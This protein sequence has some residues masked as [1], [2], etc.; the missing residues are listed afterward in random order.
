MYPARYLDMVRYFA[1]RLRRLSLATGAA[2]AL[3]GA[4]GASYATPRPVDAAPPSPPA[5]LEERFEAPIG[6]RQPT[7]EDVPSSVL[8]DEGTTTQNQR[9]LDKKLDICRGC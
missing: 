4:V 7:V 3:L 1:A 2:A 8:H 5:A 9:D 6:H